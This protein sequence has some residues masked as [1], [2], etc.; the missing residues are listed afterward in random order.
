M[1]IGMQAGIFNRS[2]ALLLLA[3]LANFSGFHLLFSVVP[4]YASEAGGGGLGAGLATAALMLTTVLT[5]VQVPRITRRLGYRLTFAVGLLLMGAPAFLYPLASELSAIL[6]ITLVRGL[7]F[8]ITTVVSGALIAELMPPERRGEGIGLY[9]IS[10]ALPSVVGLPFGLWIADYAGYATI[11]PIGAAA[12]LLGLA[13]VTRMDTPPPS[14]ER[15][16]GFF[17]SL[18]RPELLRP[19][20]IFSTA[21]AAF[22]VVA[23]FLPLS[24]NGLAAPALLAVGVAS[25]L[26]RWMAGRLGDR[27]GAPRLF[28]PGLVLAAAG[29][30]ALGWAGG[31]AGLLAGGLLYGAGFGVLQNSSMVALIERV[32]RPEYGLASSLWNVF[33][34]GGTGAAGLLFGLLVGAVGFAAAFSVSGAIL[35]AALSLAALERLKKY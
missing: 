22:G 7:G 31:L 4:R 33:Y 34:D 21:T 26:F 20:V 8:G 10:A 30:F 15:G 32:R 16:S 13:A 1:L 6:T 25:T 9:G 27:L 3:A 23:T 14:E 5:Q 35:L 18:A 11:F 17:S 2:V 28:A 12:P 19:L 29:M 24:A